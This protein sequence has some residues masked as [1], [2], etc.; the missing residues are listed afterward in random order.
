[1]ADM[2][3]ES[4]AWQFIDT[5]FP[6]MSHLS[7]WHYKNITNQ[8]DLSRMIVDEDRSRLDQGKKTVS[9]HRGQATIF[10]YSFSPAR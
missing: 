7:Q 9:D 2:T 5:D 10:L 4:D 6:F 1:M 8:N 3:W